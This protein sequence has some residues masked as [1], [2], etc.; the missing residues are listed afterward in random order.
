MADIPPYPLYNRTY[1]L[2]RVS[3]LHHDDVAVLEEKFLER[4][5][6]RLR[7][8]LKGDSVRGVDIDIPGTDNALPNLGPL[9][10]CTWDLIGDE[11]SWIDRHRPEASQLSAVL[12]AEQ[13]RGIEVTLDYEKHTYNALMLR[14]PDATVSPEGFTSLPLLLVKMPA[15]IR[16]V[17]LNYIRTSFDAH[18]APLRLPSA[19]LTSTLE[20]Y[21]R[22]LS[23]S[24][25]TQSI[26]DMIR[27]LQIQL[28]FPNAT[29]LLKHLDFTI[30]GRHVSGFV[31]RGKLLKASK[32]KPFTTALSTYLKA[33]LA[34]DLAHPN[35]QISRIQCASLSLSADRLKL[36]APDVSND[37][38]M[39]ESSSAPEAS[40]AQLAVHDFYTALVREATGTGQFMTVG[41]KK[42]S[43]STAGGG[44]S[45]RAKSVI[46]R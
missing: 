33:H 45:K 39:D 46:R 21:F 23:V 9:E 35:V 12:S 41:G 26:Q 6:K 1:I 27:Q 2:Y 25:S 36:V 10:D 14:D 43:V 11:D 22:Y 30:A 29:S 31:N 37:V 38:S 40:A 44:S 24:T 18:V 7:E 4:H 15:P 34:L 16:D 20:T 8:Q 32:E 19:F 13:A 28:S 3:P 5:A 17:F 42:R